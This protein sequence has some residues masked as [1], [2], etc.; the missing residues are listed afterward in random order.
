MTAQLV[1]VGIFRYPT[2][3]DEF[4]E[5]LF[6]NTIYVHALFADEA[7]KLAQLL[8]WAV[9]VGAMECLGATNFADG[10]FCRCMT[11]GTFCRHAKRAYTLGDC[12]DLGDNLVSLDDA[13]LR[14]R[15]TNT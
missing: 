5:C 3:V 15:A 7:R 8:G 2:E 10:D 9:G 1:D 11:D 12:Y 6:G 4:R 14:A 13:E